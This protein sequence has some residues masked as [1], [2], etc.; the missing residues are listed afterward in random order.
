MKTTF[1]A[2]KGE[3]EP[4]IHDTSYTLSIRRL[5]RLPNTPKSARDKLAQSKVIFVG[6]E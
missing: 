5:V 3:L 4:D 6:V 2:I 1:I